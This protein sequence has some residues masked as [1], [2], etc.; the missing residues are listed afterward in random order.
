MCALFSCVSSVANLLTYDLPSSWARTLNDLPWRRSQS[1]VRLHYSAHVRCL[2]FG[3]DFVRNSIIYQFIT[4][5]VHHMLTHS[6]RPRKLD[7]GGGRDDNL[8]PAITSPAGHRAQVT[9]RGVM[10]SYTRR[11][12]SRN[13]SA[14]CRKGSWNSALLG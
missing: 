4:T 11:R 12:T 1:T 3:F 2:M 5:D 13:T 7:V 9:S 8:F 6:M 14:C 10:T